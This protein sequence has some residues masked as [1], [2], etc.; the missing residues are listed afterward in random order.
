MVFKSSLYSLILCF[1]TFNFL[2]AQNLLLDG[3]IKD[4]NDYEI[5]FA[6]VGIIKK[7]IGTTSTM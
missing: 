5:P 6:A 2:N 4:D 3:S 1:L 7:N